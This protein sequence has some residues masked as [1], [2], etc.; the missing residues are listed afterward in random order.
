MENGEEVADPGAGVK[1]SVTKIGGESR[2]P[3]RVVG[4]STVRRPLKW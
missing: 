3:W 1:A 2:P 4:S